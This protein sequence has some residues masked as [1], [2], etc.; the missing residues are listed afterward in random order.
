MKKHLLVFLFFLLLIPFIRTGFGADWPMWRYDENRSASCPEELPAELHLQWIRHLPVPKAAWPRNEDTKDKLQFDASYEPVVSG[1]TIFVP[2]MVRDS[3]TAYDTETGKE[4][5]RFYAEGPVRFAPVAWQGK[6]YFISDD[7]YLYC[8]NATKGKLLWKFRGGPSDKKVLGNHR[9][10]SAWPARGGPVLHNGRIYFTASIWPFMGIFIHALNAETGKVVWTNSG[11]GSIYIKQPHNSPAFAG[12]SPQGYLAISGDRLL[13]SGGR[14]VPAC[15][16]LNKGTFL[17]YNC[18]SERGSGG[19]GVSVCKDG[20]INGGKVYDLFT[21]YGVFETPASVLADNA[22]YGVNKDGKLEAYS[23]DPNIERYTDKEGNK[24]VKGKPKK[25]WKASLQRKLNKVYIRAGSRLYG[26][27][28]REKIVAI[29]LFSGGKKARI[30]WSADIEGSVWNMLAADNKLFV[31]SREGS[32]FCFGSQAGTPKD[33]K[34]AQEDILNRPGRQ[35]R[36]VIDILKKMKVKKGYCLILGMDDGILINMVLRSSDLSVIGI[37]PDKKKIDRLRRVYDKA[38]LYGHRVSLHVGDPLLFRFPPYMA[39]LVLS[40]NLKAAGLSSGRKFLQQVYSVLRPYGGVACLS[41]PKARVANFIKE[42]KKLSL[43]NLKL[44]RYGKSIVLIRSG[45]LPGSADWTHQYCDPANTIASKDSIVKA[46]LGILWFGGPANAVILPRHGHGPSPQVA[47]GRL[48]IEGENLLRAVDVYTG[49]TFWER[50]FPGLGYYYRH[51]A[52]HPGANE[53]GS[54]Y[55]SLPDAVYVIY[56]EAILKLDPV[57][58]QTVREFTLADKNSGKPAKWGHISVW[59]DL[60]ITTSS[61]LF[62]DLAKQHEAGDVPEDLRVIIEKNAEWFYLAGSHA[63]ESWTQPDFDTKEWKRGKAG[64][65][66]GDNDD[67]TVLHD[68]RKKY[69]TVYIRRKFDGKSAVHSAEMGLMIRYDDAFIAY[70]NGT[71]VLRVG[72][73]KG[74]GRKAKG[75]PGHE[76]G[77]FEYFIIKDFRNYLQEDENVFAI[78]GHNTSRGSSDFSL[79][80]SLVVSGKN[81]SEKKEMQRQLHEIDE[82]DI[83]ARHSSASKKLVVMDR[84]SGNILWTR[85]AAH[86]FRHNAIAVGAGKIFCI[87]KMSKKK[88]SLLKRRGF[89]ISEIPCLYALNARTGKVIWK[90]EENVFGTWLAYSEEHDVLV[91]AGSA[92]RDRAV[93][94]VNRGIT[95]YR[96]KDG[97][98]LWENMQMKYSGPSILYHD[99]VIPSGYGGKAY[100]LISGESAEWGYSRNYGC[101]TAIASE[102]LIVF[103]SAAAGYY[104]LSNDG[105]T[106]NLGGFKSGCTSNLIAANGVLSA[107]DYTR[108][109]TCSYQNQTS[110]AFVHDPDAEMWTFG[111]VQSKGRLGINFGAPGDRKAE[112]AT[113]WLDYPSVGG[114]SPELGIKTVPDKPEWFRFH[115]SAVKGGDLRWVA[116]SGAEGLTKI[117]VTLD[118]RTSRLYTVRL[119]F[120]EFELHRAR[121]RIFSIALQ[122]KTVSRNFDIIKAAGSAAHS[123]IK[124]FRGIQ[125]RDVLEIE[126]VPSSGSPEN[127]TVICGVELLVEEKP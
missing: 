93:D 55:V 4:K 34:T 102:H 83:N 3:V 53:I 2:S 15:Y 101:N 48:F 25:L 124:E 107:P 96:G 86:N 57:T 98:V 12:V 29:D 91:Q 41:I 71:E 113:L 99:Q 92:F 32:I 59:E 76:A 108:T 85:D 58:G 52:H 43:P 11:S 37:D 47:G 66:Y 79:D 21:G 63:Q 74:R 14:T 6:L 122:G 56:K 112:N 35:P 100:S 104:D 123:V 13:V 31:V 88:I 110:L 103:R 90:T 81:G 51:T 82:V 40:E 77:D 19:Y 119:V 109:C 5:W 125:I 23:P 62:I 65:G 61:P 24:K 105:G 39:G 126:L 114:K 46:P 28:T 1:K 22:M 72:V 118:N 111:G 50:D 60:L 54:N 116:A 121:E 73:S 18:N 70:V 44:G 30:S 16:D 7:S 75:I 67:E 8:V 10:I 9:F 94:E 80:P 33:L 84:N 17:Y 89:E 20:F 117:T 115:S 69:S 49:C 127:S 27:D 45:A 106:G 36:Y 95:A 26:T 42:A 68:M 64:F 97:S 78:E 120:A 38:G 87:D